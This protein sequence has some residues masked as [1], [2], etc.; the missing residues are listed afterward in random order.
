MKYFFIRIYLFRPVFQML[1]FS[2]SKQP[3]TD[4]SVEQKWKKYAALLKKQAQTRLE[5]RYDK[6]GN[7]H[8]QLVLQ[9]CCKTKL[10]NDVARFTTHVPTCLATNQDVGGCEKLLQKVESSSTF[11]NKICACC[12]FYRPKATCFAASDVTPAQ[13]YP[14]RSQC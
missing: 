14:I 7:K 9:Y 5:S 10:K 13:F 12:A 1:S 2:G 6:A 3:Q 11:C 8:M 4:C